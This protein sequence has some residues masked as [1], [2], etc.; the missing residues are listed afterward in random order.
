VV[1]RE[2]V[3]DLATLRAVLH[4]RMVEIDWS[5]AM[6]EDAERLALDEEDLDGTTGGRRHGHARR[7]PVALT[8]EGPTP[9]QP[10]PGRKAHSPRYR[11]AAGS[12]AQARGAGAAVCGAG[13]RQER[14]WSGARAPVFARALAR[15]LTGPK[16]PLG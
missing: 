3:L 10:K 13:G 11:A 1:R 2:V 15:L 14:G 7:Q 5:L 16:I 8:G 4:Q 12:G 9:R 6:E